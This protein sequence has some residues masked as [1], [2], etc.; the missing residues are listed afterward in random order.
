M[1]HVLLVYDRASGQLLRDDEF[2]DSREALQ[3]RFRLERN[4]LARPDVE[5]VVLSAQ[6]RADIERTHAR[7][8]MS[9]DALAARIG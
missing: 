2:A 4:Y 7:Y 1:T 6:S 5:V 9:L 8:F 3:A